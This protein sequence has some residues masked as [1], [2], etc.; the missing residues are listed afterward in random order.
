MGK[1]SRVY[2]FIIPTMINRIA[3][4]PIL[5]FIS[6]ITFPL[7]IFTEDI[8]VGYINI[9]PYSMI[10]KNRPSGAAVEFLENVLA[11]VMDVKVIWPEEAIS[12]PRQLFQLKNNELDS[13]LCLIINDERVNFFAFLIIL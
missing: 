3:F 4:L 9:A 8:R 5:F 12:A 2:F 1:K 7:A 10:D 11:P 13:V 6:Y